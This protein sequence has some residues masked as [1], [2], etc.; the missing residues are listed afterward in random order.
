MPSNQIQTTIAIGGKL[1]S[2]FGASMKAAQFGIMRVERQ[3]WQSNAAM[4]KMT[5]SL[6]TLGAGYLGY[7][8]V[9]DFLSESL[10]LARESAAV[11]GQVSDLIER[12]N[13]LRGVGLRTSQAQTEQ[14]EK[15]AAFLEQQSGVNREVYM[16]GARTLLTGHRTVQ[17]IKE[18][19]SFMSDLLAY[20]ARM[21]KSSEELESTY[22]AIN[23][24]LSTGMAR[25]L[26][27]VNLL[28]TP[29][30]QR[31][32]KVYATIGDTSDAIALLRQIISR[33]FGGEAVKY[34]NSLEG[35]AAAA[36]NRMINAQR[37]MGKAL[38]PLR[39]AWLEI[40]ANILPRY[41]PYVEQ[42]LNQVNIYLQ[43]NRAWID[44]AAKATFQWFQQ[45]WKRVIESLTWMQ[46]N[47]K[48]LVPFLKDVIKLTLALK[49]GNLALAL[50]IGAVSKAMTALGTI[51]ALNPYARLLIG[52]AALA[53]AG[54]Y[55]VKNW[56]QVSS[57]IQDVWEHAFGT[58]KTGREMGAFS[59]GARLG[60]P[61][62]TPRAFGADEVPRAMR[63][64]NFKDTWMYQFREGIKSFLKTA[65]DDVNKFVS[66]RWS[67]F[68]KGMDFSPVIK[69]F[70]DV[71]SPQVEW[72]KRNILKPIK[73]DWLAFFVDIGSGFKSM[74]D[75]IQQNIIEP[76]LRALGLADQMKGK[77]QGGGSGVSGGGATGGWGAEP[78]SIY[79][80]PEMPLRPGAVRA[81]GFGPR[82]GDTNYA[83]NY[84]AYGS[85]PIDPRTG[86]HKLMPN[87]IA[88]T[89]NIMRQYGGMG[90][91]VDLLDPRTG[92]VLWAHQ[93][94]ADVS[95]LRQGVGSEARF[96]MG[97]IEQ[98]HVY[99]YGYLKIRRSKE[100][101]TKPP[102]PQQN[103][104][105]NYHSHNT[106]ENDQWQSRLASVHRGHTRELQKMLEEA[107]FEKNRKAFGYG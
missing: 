15:Q 38:I 107:A 95:M 40:W 82:A 88:M 77:F 61:G 75:Q 26:A 105:L 83:A 65:W 97:A 13:Q 85:G 79:K 27:G 22:T 100:Q 1:L 44:K 18:I 52:A 53:A 21:G 94:I 73:D 58:P 4:V 28:M 46:R 14:L 24:T 9:S 32:L 71:W 60:F 5:K 67:D 54:Y 2:S 29:V 48:W 50:S 87:D 17:Q 101:E 74:G 33:T 51:A 3:A 72:M 42:F 80:V 45:G 70:H 92:K 7:K 84:S 57:T 35:R 102:P 55:I 25:S 104:T 49:V 86:L 12:Q 16:T 66:D 41:G 96:P 103:V 106:I 43:Q 23:K 81:M 56:K 30:Q 59:P 47:S 78:S 69:N 63:I 20:Q 68:L 98:R 8:G 89:R 37:Q 64:Y 90:S 34:M 99:D 31:M 91:F 62:K 93:K 39:T 11:T 19:N 76:F 36:Q 10:K 6:I